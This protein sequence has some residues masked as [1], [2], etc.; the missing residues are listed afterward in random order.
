MFS[1]FMIFLG[2]PGFITWI[3]YFMDG[4]VFGPAWVFDILIYLMTG[5]S[6]F[7][8]KTSPKEV[9]ENSNAS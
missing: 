9:M 8:Y 7:A 1:K 2:I 3:A 6:C 5:W 4:N